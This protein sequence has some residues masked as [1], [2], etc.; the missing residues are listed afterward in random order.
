M[1]GVNEKKGD[2]SLVVKGEAFDDALV[3]RLSSLI[4]RAKAIEERTIKNLSQLHG[5]YVELLLEQKIHMK[6]LEVGEYF[7]DE[8]RNII[9]SDERVKA[10]FDALRNNTEAKSAIA[11]IREETEL[12]RKNV[13]DEKVVAEDDIGLAE[14][15]IVS[16]ESVIGAGKIEELQEWEKL[17]EKTIVGVQEDF[18]ESF[19]GLIAKSF[20]LS[21]SEVSP[22]ET[23]IEFFKEETKNF[24]QI[25]EKPHK[26]PI[27]KEEQSVNIERE[28]RTLRVKNNKLFEM[29]KNELH[30]DY[31]QY[32]TAIEFDNCCI[33]C[34]EAIKIGQLLSDKDSFN[35]RFVNTQGSIQILLSSIGLK[36]TI[37]ELCIRG[38]GIQAIVNYL[39][40]HQ[41]VKRVVVENVNVIEAMA[42]GIL[43]DLTAKNTESHSLI[44][45]ELDFTQIPIMLLQNVNSLKELSLVNCQLGSFE[46]LIEI[47]MK[48]KNLEIFELRGCMPKEY[49]YYELLAKLLVIN[50]RIT[51]LNLSQNFITP[52]SLKAIAKVMPDIK[53]IQTLIMDHCTYEKQ[54][55][56]ELEDVLF[57]I[58]STNQSLK[59]FSLKGFV[60]NDDAK[61][62]ALL[63]KWEKKA[64]NI[65]SRIELF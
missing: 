22:N 24:K 50:N 10:Y 36:T 34:E 8:L 4:S 52:K 46:K 9:H 13:K 44:L 32:L 64:P 38:S 43:I 56:T 15:E 45:K 7:K 6:W 28:D 19:A 26:Q 23:P 41:K 2:E 57:E 47:L 51:T 59:V 18:Y 48:S 11:K 5:N 58:I 40:Q 60:L 1:K 12:L 21:S 39:Q 17:V 65:R 33:D 14:A 31:G 55:Q 42:L 35:L 30:S 49:L 25:N 29:I 54:Y 53:A 63:A 61:A 62:M 37:N 16:I 20:T 27:H 3:E